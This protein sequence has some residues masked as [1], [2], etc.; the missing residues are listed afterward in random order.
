MQVEDIKDHIQPKRKYH[1]QQN[2][3]KLQREGKHSEN[4]F[5]ELTIKKRANKAFKGF[6][7][8]KAIFFNEL[9][10]CLSQITNIY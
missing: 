1:I 3:Q 9:S 2:N 6:G 8:N 10:T 5:L 4:I 7:K